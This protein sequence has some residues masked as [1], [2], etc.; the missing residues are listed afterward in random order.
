MLWDDAVSER[1]ELGCAGYSGVGDVAG[2][3][4]HHP[5]H[6]TGAQPTSATVSLFRGV[7]RGCLCNALP[8]GYCGRVLAPAS[9]VT[10]VFANDWNCLVRPVP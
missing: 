2:R 5:L 10:A 1:L 3:E 6:E 9:S 8:V 7:G 4:A